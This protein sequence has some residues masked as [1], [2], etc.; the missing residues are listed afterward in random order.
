VIVKKG[1]GGAVG[2]GTGVVSIG[3][4]MLRNGFIIS[5]RVITPRIFLFSFTTHNL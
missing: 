2:I 1:D 4:G 5:V 3:A